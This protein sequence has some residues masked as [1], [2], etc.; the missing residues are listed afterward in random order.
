[1][2]F[3][4]SQLAPAGTFMSVFRHFVEVFKP[5]PVVMPKD[6]QCAEVLLQLGV[7]RRALYRDL[8]NWVSTGYQ[9]AAATSKAGQQNLHTIS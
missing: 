3:I 4:V 9:R 8:N 6:D 2:T 7:S 5:E 1:M